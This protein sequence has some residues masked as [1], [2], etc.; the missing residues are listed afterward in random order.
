MDTDT[1]LNNQR[2][3]TPVNHS[4]SNS[5]HTTN[6]NSGHNSGHSSH[7]GSNHSI[8]TPLKNNN[9]SGINNG[10]CIN[11]NDDDVEVNG[12][13]AELERRL[14]MFENMF[15]ALSGKLDQ[16]FKKYDMIIQSQQQQINELN[17]IVSTLLNDQ[18][19]NA[20]I[21]RDKL[22]NSVNGISSQSSL[23]SG[24]PMVPPPGPFQQ[25]QQMQQQQQQ[26]QQMIP[27]QQ[28]PMNGSNMGRRSSNVT[29]VQT[30]AEELLEDILNNET[31]T[32]TSDDNSNP[33]SATTTTTITTSN[34]ITATRRQSGI[35]VMDKPPTFVKETYDPSNDTT[36][37]RTV[38]MQY[39]SI[40]EYTTN[41]GNMNGNGIIT[42][43]LT[44][45]GNNLSP[46]DGN[47]RTR[48]YH[49]IHQK[50]HN[51]NGM[52]P[53]VEFKFIKSPHSVR[54][55]WLEY[56]E[57]VKGQPSI[58]EMEALYQ[59]AWR[60]EPAVTKRYSRRK[61]LC[62]AIENGIS[63]GYDLEN[64]INLLENHRIMNHEKG[65]KQPIGW[66]CQPGNIPQVFK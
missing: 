47:Q 35:M 61:V 63:K 49:N 28:V 2:Q 24:I 12:R 14:I 65:I 55:I 21:I 39:P 45:N 50:Y 34:N 29:F 18:V 44:H 3:G 56:V 1:L 11:G 9:N 36:E 19:S 51:S 5:N 32:T 57:G 22:S 58:K 46:S 48:T 64:I 8:N 23:I 52:Q 27:Q 6:N 4:G 53:I 42:T 60:R 33:N 54:E 7:R 13:V 66:L 26:Q 38:H 10:N 62:K 41:N 30:G 20:E 17:S 37:K 31:T 25:Q 15:H 59:S 40:T 16:H 43:Q